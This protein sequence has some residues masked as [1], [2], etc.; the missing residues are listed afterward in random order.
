[1]E[2]LGTCDRRGRGSASITVTPLAVSILGD[3]RPAMSVGGDVNIGPDDTDR[4]IFGL[5]TWEGRRL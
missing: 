2:R 4:E 3:T 5:M 1:M